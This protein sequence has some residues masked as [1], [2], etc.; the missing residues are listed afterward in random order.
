M[1]RKPRAK[2]KL[3]PK[4]KPKARP[5]SRRKPAR[6]TR[7][8]GHAGDVEQYVDDVFSGKEVVGKLVR[9]A[10]KRYVDDLQ[11]AGERGL[12]CDEAEA[13]RRIRFVEMLRH[14]TGEFY[15]LPFT[16]RPFQKFILWNLFG[17]K[18]KADKL[19]RY[20]DAF[21]SMGR[22][23]GKSPL[24]AA[25]LN[26]LMVLDGESRA[27]IKVA[28]V[29]RDQ[30]RIVFDEA[31]RQL[32]SSDFLAG[33]CE[34]W[35][36]SLVFKRMN[37]SIVPL[38]GEGG[39]KDGFNLHAF[40][41]DEVHA[42]KTEHREL[43][44]K[45]ETAMSK[46]RQP[47]SV[48]TTT[49]GNDQST[50]WQQLYELSRKVVQGV[51]VDDGHFSFIAEIDDEDVEHCLHDE[52][53]W[54]KANPNLD[55]SVK[56]DQMRR[57]A[58]RAAIDPVFRLDVLRYYMNRRVRDAAKPITPEMWRVGSGCL[59]EL[60]KKACHGGLDLG[61]RNDLASFYLC[62][63]LDGN[64]FA[65]KGWN[66]IPREVPKA[67][68]DLQAE[69]WRTWL[70][71]SHLI[72]TDGN[73]TDI[74]SIY[75]KISEAQKSFHLKSVAMDPNNA[76]AVGLHL[77]NHM[78]IESFDFAQSAANYN[79]PLREFTKALAE[80]R[81]LHGDDPVLGWAADNLLLRTNSTGLVMP[82]K[83]KSIDKIDP[84]VAA[85]MA[86]ARCLY[87]DTQILVPRVRG[88]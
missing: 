45:L 54:P 19:R 42:W 37:S 40:V 51:F 80:G 87:G 34:F 25:I 1:A 31:R 75:A 70:N 24:A 6:K 73:A 69:P 11:H 66:W 84:I 12:F 38:G 43:W 29:E 3:A 41:A 15:G 59:P 57:F 13:D 55:V 78:T 81:I 77:V 47:L 46:R 20:R 56:R 39:S 8:E 2:P 53:S 21:I 35:K 32:Q 30:A 10:V 23:N 68:R 88:L 61:W 60:L 7:R 14:S 82:A 58:A 63:P 16:L 9:A 22:G 4:G 50:L 83:D 33:G 62:F 36:N 28:A 85:L 27:E 76:R 65:F 71:K 67:Q 17:W 72:A 79:E 44:S 49:A 48:V 64:R 52:T 18:R 86:F 74:D 5:I 26:C